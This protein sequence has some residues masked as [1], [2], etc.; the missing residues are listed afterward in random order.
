MI[1]FIFTSD[2]M[3]Q[4]NWPFENILINCSFLFLFLAM[5]CYWMYLSSFFKGTFLKFGQSG[6][7]LANLTILALLIFRWLNSGHFPL[8]NLAT[9]KERK[10]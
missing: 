7:I 10:L 6:T 8:S 1:F 3:I 9:S 5:I 4:T 2:Q